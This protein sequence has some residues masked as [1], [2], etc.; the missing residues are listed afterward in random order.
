MSHQRTF[1]QWHILK[2]HLLSVRRIRIIVPVFSPL[3]RY[4]PITEITPG[5]NHVHLATQSLSI[6]STLPDLYLTTVTLA[7]QPATHV[8]SFPSRH[9]PL[10]GRSQLNPLRDRSER[11]R[12]HYP[13]IHSGAVHATRSILTKPYPLRS[14]KAGP[15]PLGARPA[16]VNFRHRSPAA[17][18]TNPALTFTRLDVALARQGRAKRVLGATQT[19]DGCSPS[20][21]RRQALHKA[22]GWRSQSVWQLGSVLALERLARRFVRG[23]WPHRDHPHAHSSRRD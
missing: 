13:R 6:R 22:G 15:Y 17:H 16:F 20:P 3:Q 11:G 8:A 9:A 7:Q 10:R 14:F 1:R 2:R 19:D 5:E 23:P 21:S 4:F 12:N 18:L